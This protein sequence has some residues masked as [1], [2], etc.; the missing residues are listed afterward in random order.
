MSTIDPAALVTGQP[1]ERSHPTA[2]TIWVG[3][4]AAGLLVGFGSFVYQWSSGLGVTGLSN[5]I[6][7][8]LYIVAFM[9]LVGISAGG[10]IVV[11]GAEL[12]GTHRFE[13]IN[14]LAVVCSVAAVA[15][16]AGTILPDLGRPQR[17]WKMIVQPHLTSPLVWDMAVLGIYLVIGVVDLWILTRR[18]VPPRALRVMSIV[19]LPVAILVHSVTAWI[20]GLLVAR[21]FWNTPLLAPLFIS[22]ALV[23]GTALVIVTGFVVERVS[24]FEVGHE[25]YGGLRKLLVWFVA[26]DGFLLFTEV[27]TTYVS[28]EPDHRDQLDILLTGRLAPVFWAEVT[29]GLLVPAVV[30]VSR[31]GRRPG[32]VAASSVLLLL[33]VFAKRI[34]I[35]FAAEFEPLVGLEPGIPGGRPG[36]EFRP[37]EVYFP[38]WVEAGVLIGMAAFFLAIVTVGV[39]RAVLPHH[40]ES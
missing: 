11:A 39:R 21:P 12:A 26:A 20:F 13:H 5:T 38:S 35:L 36:Q 32:W 27:M 10:L 33:G 4:L 7:W 1:A 9:F 3:A 15:T 6:T 31:L 14:R 8:G 28:G 24:T 40:T 34:N 25:I 29:V 30:L 2:W 23:S 18:P 17:A 37:D 19:S 22:S 16:A